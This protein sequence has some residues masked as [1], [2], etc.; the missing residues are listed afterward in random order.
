MLAVYSSLNIAVVISESYCLLV[1]TNARTNTEYF[2]IEM[3]HGSFFLSFIAI[4]FAFILIYFN[5]DH[6]LTINVINF[7]IVNK[8]MKRKK[9]MMVNNSTN[10]EKKTKQLSLTSNH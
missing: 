8:I 1:E 2:Q 9:K 10:M 5:V 4:R 6:Q 3:Y 7:T